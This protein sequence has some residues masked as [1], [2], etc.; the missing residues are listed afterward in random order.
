[1]T[2]CSEHNQVYARTI[3]TVMPLDYSELKPWHNDRKAHY[4]DYE[5]YKKRKE[6]EVIAI[7]ESLY[8]NLSKHIESVFSSTSLTYRDD[9]LSPEG[10]MYG[11][12]ESVGS[13]HTRVDG[14]FITGQNVF[15]HGLCGVVM[16]S[17][18]VAESIC[19]A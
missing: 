14:L 11:M 6:H 4:A 5:A 3:E 18:Q 9:Y 19:E 15:L 1:M 13:I 12:S 16:T 8:P 7:V 2:P 10:A 17:L